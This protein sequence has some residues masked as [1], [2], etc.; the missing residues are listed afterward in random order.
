MPTSLYRQVGEVHLPTAAG[1]VTNAQLFSCFDPGA[2]ILRGLFTAAINAELTAAWNVVRVGTAL[3]T[4]APVQDSTYQL[5]D[6]ALLREAKFQFPLLAVTRGDWE[7][8]EHT[9]DQEM[10][11]QQW[12]IDYVLGPLS[13]EDFRKLGA[14]L[15][16]VRTVVQQ[17]IRMRGHP[18]YQS[19]ALQFFDGKGHFASVKLLSGKQG[20]ATWGPE[21]EGMIVHVLSMVLETEEHDYDMPGRDAAFAGFSL[22]TNAGGAAEGVV[23]REIEVASE[24]NPWLTP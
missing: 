13:P 2:D 23:P 16:A 5:P 17:T 15:N 8:T 10:L 14:V 21:G 24:F 11:K 9:L 19:G 7:I 20:P 18:T 6:K 1:D 22:S 4:V 12:S 3:A